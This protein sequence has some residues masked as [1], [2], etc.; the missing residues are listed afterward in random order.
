MKL[1]SFQDSRIL[2]ARPSKHFYPPPLS[3]HFICKRA[4]G[5][6][7][8]RNDIKEEREIGTEEGGGGG[9]DDDS[10]SIFSSSRERVFSRN[11]C[12]NLGARM[13][14]YREIEPI[15]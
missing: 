11:Q 1:V 14:K 5:P 8:P 15:N 6:P 13:A 4:A 10:V 12:L 9:G 2:D 3:L 7:P